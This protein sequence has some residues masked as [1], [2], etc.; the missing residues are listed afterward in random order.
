MLFA[1]GYASLREV[2][3]Q[4]RNVPDYLPA[5]D[6]AAWGRFHEGSS[7][8][9]LQWWASL[10]EMSSLPGLLR[11]S[12]LAQIVEILSPANT[13]ALAQSVHAMRRSSEAAFVRSLD[14]WHSVLQGLTTAAM[15]QV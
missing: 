12:S 10:S 5:Q 1:N 11:W 13:E 4:I 2:A 7:W 15:Q 3:Q 8:T 9:E 14:F 6:G